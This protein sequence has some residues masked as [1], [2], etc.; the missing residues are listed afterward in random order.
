MIPLLK[1]PDPIGWMYAPETEIP[2]LLKQGW[3]R[4]T[5][6]ERQDV[7]AAK[8]KAEIDSAEPAEPASLDE[9]IAAWEKKFGKRADRRKSAETLMQ[10]LGE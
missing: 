5:E 2:A 7:I 3:Q 10:E 4:S 9:L 6:K 1:F 8:R